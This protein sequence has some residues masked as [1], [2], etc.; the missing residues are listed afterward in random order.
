MAWGCGVS[1]GSSNGLQPHSPSPALGEEGATV[2]FCTGA[3]PSSSA[4]STPRG[5]R[6]SAGWAGSSLTPLSLSTP[7]HTRKPGEDATPSPEASDWAKRGT[8][9][10]SQAPILAIMPV[11][12]REALSFSPG[13][14]AGT[15]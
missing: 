9:Q 14:E 4:N 6:P 2:V 13:W 15:M 10:D 12:E 3:L 5:K 1:E 11:M 8:K 7:L